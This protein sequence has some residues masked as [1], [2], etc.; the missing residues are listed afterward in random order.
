LCNDPAV[1]G[2]HLCVVNLTSQLTRTSMKTLRSVNFLTFTLFVAGAW[3]TDRT[4]VWYATTQQ[5]NVPTVPLFAFAD[6]KAPAM[7]YVQQVLSN[8][9]HE[10]WKDKHAPQMWSTATAILY[11]GETFHLHFSVPNDPYLGLIDPEG[12]FFYLVFPAET[13]VGALT[14]LIES[15]YFAVLQTL[16]INTGSLQAD[17]YTYGVYEN[18]P[19]FTVTGTYTF[20][21]G[22]NL[23]V[24]DLG[25]LEKVTVRYV[26]T[27]RPV[28]VSSKTVMN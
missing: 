2:L 16:A 26:H 24:D 8:G 15:K 20:I 19:V 3:M 18:Q 1:K 6:Q 12:H 9:I 13:A 10:T 22:E 21:L 7:G 27:Q 14:P 23:H 11:K 28:R 5:P 25:L 17:P 4:T